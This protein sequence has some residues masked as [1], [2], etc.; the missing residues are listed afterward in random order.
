M[1]EGNATDITIGG[2]VKGCLVVEF[3]NFYENA[4]QHPLEV[5]DLKQ[6][7]TSDKIKMEYINN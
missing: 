1:T 7:L 3:Y 6:Y 4:E 2:E 5:D